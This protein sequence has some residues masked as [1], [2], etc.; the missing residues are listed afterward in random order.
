MDNIN[1]LPV[2]LLGHIFNYLSFRDRKNAYAVCTLWYKVLRGVRFQRQRRVYLNRSFD[3][4]LNDLEIRVLRCFRNIHIYF[5]DAAGFDDVEL[6]EKYDIIQFKYLYQRTPEDRLIEF[7]FEMNMDLESLELS[8]SFESCREILE[9]R[10]PRIRNLRELAL[11]FETTENIIPQQHSTTWTIQHHRVEKLR[12]DFPCANLPLKVITPNLNSLCVDTNCRQGFQII[13]A[14]C[15][16]LQCLEVTIKDAETVDDI[17]ALPFPSLTHLQTW[18]H[19]DNDK[20]LQVRYARTR[21]KYVDLEKEEQFVIGMPK[22][23]S[24]HSANNLMFFRISTALSKFAKQL[25]ELTLENQEMDLEQ[26]K[27]FE[28]IPIKVLNIR[29]CKILTSSQ[30]LPTLNMP[31]LNSLVLWYNE[32]DI[33]FDSGLSELKS[34]KMTLFKSKNHKVLHKICNNLPNLEHLEI[35]A[36]R[37]LVNTAFRY[38]HKLTKLRSLKLIVCETKTRFWTHCSVIPTLRRIDLIECTLNKFTLQQLAKVFPGLSELI[39]EECKVQFNDEGSGTYRNTSKLDSE[40]RRSCLQQ[41]NEA[42]PLCT[43]SLY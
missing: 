19:G 5:F 29:R 30:S 21:N 24:F 14:Y 36:Y 23:K 41:L 32:S 4:D 7:L 28:A 31:H 10:L 33:I 8:R 43:I 38:L 22:L 17:M 18:P 34:L 20:E 3:D 13:E 35:W 15:R 26:I 37:M 1:N 40:R 11:N 16:Q 42:F 39:L 6:Q 25:V 9:N 12:M 27:A 2:E